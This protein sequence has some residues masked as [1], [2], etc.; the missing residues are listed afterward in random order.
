MTGPP[1]AVLISEKPAPGNEKHSDTAPSA[2][3]N[4]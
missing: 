1:G 2:A 4:P 3:K